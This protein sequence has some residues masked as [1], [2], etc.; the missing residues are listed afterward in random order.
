MLLGSCNSVF[1]QIANIKSK[2]KNNNYN[3]KLD[4]PSHYGLLNVYVL[5]H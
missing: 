1:A 3:T 2:Q 4:T 5:D